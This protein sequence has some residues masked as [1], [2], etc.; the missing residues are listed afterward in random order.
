MNAQELL[1]W[2]DEVRE[3][4]RLLQLEA[5]KVTD[6]DVAGEWHTREIAWRDELVAK[7]KT[8]DSS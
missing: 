3:C 4:G 8:T 1:A 2:L 7:V 5:R 6:P